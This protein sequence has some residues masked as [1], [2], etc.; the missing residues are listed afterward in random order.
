MQVIKADDGLV[1]PISETA[2][3][4]VECHLHAAARG[5]PPPPSPRKTN[6]TKLN[7]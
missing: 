5:P 1:W 3:P 7:L 4:A 2:A 6:A